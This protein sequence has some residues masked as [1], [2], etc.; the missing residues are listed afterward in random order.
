MRGNQRQE[1]LEFRL[2][3]HEAGKV[4]RQVGGW[5][6]ERWR[7]R[8]AWSRAGAP[9]NPANR[10]N[11]AVSLPGNGLDEGRRSGLANGL[12]DSEDRRV[13]PGIAVEK[14]IIP[15]EPLGKVLS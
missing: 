6:L 15:P 12:P 9:L 10:R 4:E 11:E 14:D 1:F 8:S 2:A 5:I 13:Q 3:T 7:R